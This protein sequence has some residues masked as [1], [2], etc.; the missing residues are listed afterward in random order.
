MICVDKKIIE[1]VAEIA[2]LKL[3]DEETERFEKEFEN[4]LEHFSILEKLKLKNEFGYAT[5]NVNVLRDDK[6][7]KQNAEKILK[8]VPKI[9]GKLLKVPKGL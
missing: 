8:N 6:K 9:E 5:E 7:R 1:K 2:R 3:S 4:I